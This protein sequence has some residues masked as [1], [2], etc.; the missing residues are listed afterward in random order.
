[1]IWMLAIGF[2]LLWATAAAVASIVIGKLVDAYAMGMAMAILLC[3]FLLAP[4]VAIAEE[5]HDHS[6]MNSTVD[7]FLKNWNQPRGGDKR[8]VSCCHNR[9]C[10][11]VETRPMNGGVEFKSRVTGN[12]TL[13]PPKLLEQNQPDT[14]WSPNGK[15]W[16]CQSRTELNVICAT[17]GDPGI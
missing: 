3:A 8:Y 15:P 6:L 16:V 11:E 9:D 4:P 14:E 10:N 5:L 2:S 13:I 7:S 17:L 1:M 12:W